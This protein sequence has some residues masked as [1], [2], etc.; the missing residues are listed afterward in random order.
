MTM[1]EDQ[2][3]D[4]TAAAPSGAPAT[5]GRLAPEPIGLSRTVGYAI[6]FVGP[7]ASVVLGWATVIMF[8]GFATPV[9]VV[10]ALVAAV[11]C[12][13]SIGAFARKLP[14]AGSLFTYNTHAFG[15]RIG[16]LSGWALFFAYILFAPAGL[17]ASGYFLS[18]FVDN[19]F[20]VHISASVLML[21]ALAFTTALALRGIH[22][23]AS[24]DLV[25]VVIEMVVIIALAVTILAKVGLGN[26]D[27]GTFNPAN[28]LNG[29]LSDISLAMVYGVVAFSGFESAATLAEESRDPRRNIPRA[30]LSAVT[31]VGAF[32]VLVLFAQMQG[33]GQE[34]I[35]KF[36][37][38]GAQLNTLTGQ[39]WSDDFIWVIDLVV[40]L[41]TLGF[42]I[43]TFNSGARML[44]A[45]GR[46]E[47]LPARL[48]MVAPDRGTP[49]NAIIATAV[50]SL[51]VGLPMTI[52]YGGFDTFAYL[53]AI[54]GLLL[55]LLYVIVN[56]GVIVAFRRSYRDE[57]NPIRHVV[58]PLIAAGLFCIPLVGSFY[59][60]PASP[61]NVLPFVALGWI[62]VGAAVVTV[63]GR[64][65]PEKL[66]RIGKAFED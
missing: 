50:F 32:Y 28:S 15:T 36:I 2:G 1:H 55:T 57:A 4:T 46:E 42:T 3:L 49:V 53:G 27:F 44:F 61:Y 64:R 22:T 62:L 47:M 43:A 8:A 5:A 31:I 65:A 17:G 59:P 26:L 51:V 10:L 7:S 25:L 14:S 41:G 23:S 66:A 12:A 18:Q 45:M 52:I 39:Y 37:E 20:D 33:I 9:V 16:F 29:K 60:A 30:L 34:G 24:V 19:A 13:M 58:V 11:L 21:A 35:G 54:A 56:L 38:D 63:I 48:G 40:A 6:G